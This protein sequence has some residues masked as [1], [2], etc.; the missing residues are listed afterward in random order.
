MVKRGC[1]GIL[2]HGLL[3]LEL[4]LRLLPYAAKSPVRHLGALC[5]PG[6]YT[7]RMRNEGG[8]RRV[9]CYGGRPLNGWLKWRDGVQQQLSKGESERVFGHGKPIQRMFARGAFG[10]RESPVNPGR[11]GNFFVHYAPDAA[12]GL[13]CAEPSA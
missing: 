9:F 12:V 13:K 3:T 2:Q 5:S 10:S 6:F 7:L 4:L 8:H 11:E 1:K